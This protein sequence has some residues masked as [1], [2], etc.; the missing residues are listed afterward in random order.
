[1]RRVRFRRAGRRVGRSRV[2]L[3]GAR[4]GGAG[5]GCAWL[6]W[7]SWLGGSWRRDGAA[8]A[9][10]HRGYLGLSAR[11]GYVSLLIRRDRREISFSLGRAEPPAGLAH[12][13]LD[14]GLRLGDGRRVGA[15]PC[16][17]RGGSIGS[18]LIVCPGGDPDPGPIRLRLRIRPGNALLG[19]GLRLGASLGHARFSL[20]HARFNLGC[21]W[22]AISLG[23]ARPVVGPVVGPVSLGCHACIGRTWLGVS[24][25]CDVLTA[26]RAGAQVLGEWPRVPVVGGG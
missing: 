12:P 16:L 11:D 10:V 5:L 17:R 6:G 13:G 22:P 19:V 14:A 23:H 2:G 4:P 1:M 20:G 9:R 21:A 7:S 3:G 15:R 24:I 8:R 18:G 26:A 25:P